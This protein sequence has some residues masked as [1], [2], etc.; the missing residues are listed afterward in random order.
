MSGTQ[1]FDFSSL[2]HL[3]RSSKTP[4]SSAFAFRTTTQAHTQESPKTHLD[5]HLTICMNVCANGAGHVREFSKVTYMKWRTSSGD[6]SISSGA[7]SYRG[8]ER[9]AHRK[10]VCIGDEGGITSNAD[11]LLDRSAIHERF[12]RTLSDLR[13]GTMKSK[14][15]DHILSRLITKS[16]CPVVGPRT[17]D[18]LGGHVY[19]RCAYTAQGTNRPRRTFARAHRVSCISSAATAIVWLPCRSPSSK[20]ALLWTFKSARVNLWRGITPFGHQCKHM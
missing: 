19:A 17:T 7:P 9:S 15:Y 2:T 11:D 6:G 12:C 20:F 13:E 10:W 18:L 8:C 5:R 14:R 16:G 1:Q 4:R 3:T